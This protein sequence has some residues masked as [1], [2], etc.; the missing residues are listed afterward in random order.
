MKYSQ[1]E[2]KSRLYEYGESKEFKTREDALEKVTKVEKNVNT[3]LALI[4][5][6][7]FSK[8]KIIEENNAFEVV[9]TMEIPSVFELNN[10][11]SQ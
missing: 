8:T 7:P 10:R 1:I 9:V 5:L 4:R 11:N 3:E 2:Q 6:L